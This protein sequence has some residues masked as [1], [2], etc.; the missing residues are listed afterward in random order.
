MQDWHT[1]AKPEPVSC[2]LNMFRTIKE[3]LPASIVVFLV[4]LP[5]CLGIALASG[6]P[7]FSGLISGIVGGIVI[8]SLSGSSVSVSGP[9]AGLTVIVLG[10]IEDLGG[11]DIFLLSVALAGILQFILGVLRA[12]IIAYYFPTAVI[13]GMLAAIG[14]ILILKQIPHALGYDADY[15]GDQSFIQADE[16]NTFSEI[17]NAVMDPSP[18]AIIISVVCLAILI[19]FE[20]RFIKRLR[21]FQLIPGALIT[22][23]AGTGLNQLFQRIAPQLHLS[24]DH[25]VDIPVSAN[26]SQFIG[27]FTLPDFTAFGNAQVYVTALTI[28]IV[29]S[30]ETLLCIDAADKLDPKRR[31]TPASRELRA[32]GIG[33]LV[34]GLIGGLPTTAV[35]VRSSA[36]ISAGAES[37]MSAVLHGIFL[38]LSIIFIPGLLNLIPL[39]CLA[40]VLL[41]VGY[42]LVKPSIFKD[43]YSKGI[44]QLVPFVVTLMAIMLT[45]L[46]IG[47]GIGL[48]VGILFVIRSNFHVAI[49]V[50]KHN[51]NYLVRMHKDV[52]F[53]NK[54]LLVEILDDIPENSHVIIDATRASFIDQDILEVITNFEKNATFKSIE[55][56]REGLDKPLRK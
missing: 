34:S 49:R 44:N 5:L 25:I 29:A 46:L 37:K 20:Q 51:E 48:A 6:A 21:I 4:A 40:A 45:D 7:L 41:V 12:G 38:L 13:K 22:V 36:N 30:L 47:I 54:A 8:G 43:M 26:F 53:L 32:Q 19:L 55:V 2:N 9:A 31:V 10:A 23:L 1:Q 50:T 42:K 24:G 14:L 11:Y 35:I 28:A 18:G 3:D 39:S 17:I 27:Q 15:E 56:T 52:S 16:E 33:N